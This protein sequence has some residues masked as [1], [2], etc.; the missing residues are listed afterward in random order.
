MIAFVWM[1]SLVFASTGTLD[2]AVQAQ[3]AERAGVSLRDAHLALSGRDAEAAARFSGYFA[4][5]GLKPLY[6][7]LAVE[8]KRL[9]ERCSKPR[10]DTKACA[11][12][13]QAAASERGQL[14]LLEA[15]EPKAADPDRQ[16]LRL[17]LAT[18]AL[19]EQLVHEVAPKV[20]AKARGKLIATS[21]RLVRLAA[22]K[23][24]PKG[25][26][27]GPGAEAVEKDLAAALGE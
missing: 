19:H 2:S 9:E 26:A 12:Q 17:R 21:L 13:K 14:R 4:K 15:R 6:A 22:L 10:A 23:H 25:T 8:A 16:R 24:D 5:R 3:V 20:P 18:L 7:A 27:P 11:E 1:T